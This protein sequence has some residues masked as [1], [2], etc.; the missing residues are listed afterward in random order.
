MFTAVFVQKFQFCKRPKILHR[1][2]TKNTMDFFCI[3]H[4]FNFIIMIRLRQRS[5]I[6]ATP[7]ENMWRMYANIL[8]YRLKLWARLVVVASYVS[9]ALA[10]S[11]SE[12]PCDWRSVSRSVLVSS[13]VWGSWPDIYLF[14][15]FGES[16]SPVYGGALS[17]ERSGLPLLGQLTPP[18]RLYSMSW[19]PIMQRGCRVRGRIHRRRQQAQEY[20]FPDSLITLNNTLKLQ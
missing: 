16:Y 19:L 18:F 20:P 3:Q 4:G 11:E 5:L 12:S 15:Y 7:S 6:M 10:S 14:I 9:D 2:P 13:P 17:D 1:V 8:T